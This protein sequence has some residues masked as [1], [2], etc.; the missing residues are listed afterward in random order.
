MKKEVLQK[1]KMEKPVYYDATDGE[2]VIVQRS[3]LRS[4]ME[5]SYRYG[6]GVGR[7][8]GFGGIAIASLL[9]LVTAPGFNN[10]LN[11]SGATWRALFVLTFVLFFSLTVVTILKMWR[12]K[13]PDIEIWFTKEKEIIGRGKN[14]KSQR[15]LAS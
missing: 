10:F 4:M 1:L 9:A 11:L 6:L 5:A 15:K 14:S 2:T 12:I 3:K 8:S 13:R 7:L